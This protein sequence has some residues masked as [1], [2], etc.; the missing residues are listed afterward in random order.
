MTLRVTSPSLAQKAPGEI[1]WLKEP[2]PKLEASL[3]RDVFAVLSL[4][5]NDRSTAHRETLRS[6]FSSASPEVKKAEKELADFSASARQMKP[7]T[8]VPIMREMAKPRETHIQIRGDFLAKDK[9][10]TAGLPAVFPPLPEGEQ[11][12]RLAMARWLVSEENPLTARVVANRYWESLFGQG[13]VRT[14]EEFGSQGELPTHPELLDW[15]ATE[16]VRLDWDLKALL[17]TIVLSAA[18][19]QSSKVEAKRAEKDPFNELL[20]R[21]P[22]QRLS[23]EMVRDQALAAS[24]LLS[25]KMYGPPVKPPQPNM[26]LKAAFGPSLDWK[27]STG[28]DKFRRG[29]YV[30]WRRSNPYPSMA[31]FDAPNRFVCNVR[32]TPTNT[33]LQALVTMND[34]VYV[35]AAQALARRMVKA[36]TSP[37]EKIVRGFRLCLT[38]HP[39]PPETQRL[40]AF[41]EHVRKTYAADANAAKAMATDPIGPLPA[42]SD[43][44]EL[45]SWTVVGNVLLNLDEVFLKR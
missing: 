22:R 43:V 42:G 8:T 1:F 24:G 45:A 41:Y 36:G 26:G 11:T 9:K 30:N 28:E 20:S 17:K 31:T 15:L 23:A 7:Q 37:E 13:L 44:V 2:L 10:V 34:P 6:F 32:R 39:K 4:P 18:Y 14:S 38:R 3:P 33:P 12:N 16:L 19:R 40:L 5:E 35:E 25:R 21:G 27:T 29:I